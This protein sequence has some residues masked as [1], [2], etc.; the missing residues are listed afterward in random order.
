MKYLAA[1]AVHNLKILNRLAKGNT[2]K[3]EGGT[4]RPPL[5]IWYAMDSSARSG[6]PSG[7]GTP[8]FAAI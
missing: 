4:Y 3:G 5:R 1:T 7:R 6:F 8:I 2:A